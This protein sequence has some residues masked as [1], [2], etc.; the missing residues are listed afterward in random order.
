MLNSDDVSIGETIPRHADE[1]QRAKLQRGRNLRFVVG[2]T[3]CLATLSGIAGCG[4]TVGYPLTSVTPPSGYQY[5]TGNWQF[6]ATDS[7]GQAFSALAGFINESSTGSNGTHDAISILEIVPASCYQGAPLL[8]SSGYVSTTSLVLNSFSV[9]GQYVSMNLTKD[10]SA[11]H[12]TGAYQV[13][14]GCANGATG[15]V[16]GVRYAPITGTYTGQGNNTQGLVLTLTQ[17]AT[18][19]GNGG[20]PLSGTA[21]FTG[22]SCFTTGAVQS[23]M[24]SALGSAFTLQIAAADGGSV[25]LQGTFDTG[26]STL[27]ISSAAI[28]GDS[29]AGNL[30]VTNLQGS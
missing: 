17:S 29:C 14:G 8:P 19:D 9:N 5:L 18:P 13:A 10:T 16:T 25:A 12:L 15:T 7:S 6:T 20:S 24:S 28:T 22:I 1:E 4:G 3:V 2:A 21:A 23:S 27:T 11:K 30:N 26:A